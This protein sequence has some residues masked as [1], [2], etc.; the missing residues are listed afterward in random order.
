MV[1][2]LD[3]S[4]ANGVGMRLRLHRLQAQDVLDAD[5]DQHAVDR[6]PGPVA[7]E[8]LEERGPA[9]TVGLGVG[10]LRRIAARGVDQHRFLGEQPVAIARAADCLDLGGL[11]ALGEREVQAGIDECRRLARARQGPIMMYQGR[12]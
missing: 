10:I 7:L 4:R 3:Q 6:L 11:G 12:S 1:M 2:Q 8:H 5:A 9:S